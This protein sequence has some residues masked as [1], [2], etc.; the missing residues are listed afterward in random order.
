MLSVPGKF[1][2]YLKCLKNE[3]CYDFFEKTLGIIGFE[4]THFGDDQRYLRLEIVCFEETFDLM[5]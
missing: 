1:Y 4:G 2:V 3:N 5:M